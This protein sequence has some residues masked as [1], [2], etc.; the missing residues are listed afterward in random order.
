MSGDNFT[1]KPRAA[2]GDVTNLPEKRVFSSIS[3]DLGLKSRGGYGENGDSVFAKQVCPGV[4]NLVKRKCETKSRDDSGNEKGYDSLTTSSKTHASKENIPVVSLVA[5]RPSDIK[6]ASNF[7]DGSVDL[8]KSSGTGTQS[9]GE[10]SCAS[11]GSMYTS[12]GLCVKDSDDEGKVTSNV[13][14][15]NPVVQGLVGGASTSDGIVS[16]VGRLA[17]DKCGSV[18]WSRLPNSQGVKSFELEKCTT[19]KGDVC[20]NLNA[21]ADMLKACSCS[22]CLKAAYIWS[23]LYY[24][25]IKGRQSA[26]RKSQK[27]AGILVNKYSRGK[28]T[29]IHS[30]VNSNKSLKLESDLTDHWR[31]LFRHMEDMFANESSQLQAGYVTLKDLRDNCKIDLE[32]ITG[33]RSDTL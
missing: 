2:L 31:S 19:L 30:Q 5:D 32:R 28:Q 3:D 24:Q 15:I 21:G 6:E 4:E 27:E 7:I 33:M 14:L 29:D 8:V 18:E 17:R 11:S 20:A 13:M 10:V 23:D 22:F 16:G 25:D 12:S 1:S 26:L 9:I